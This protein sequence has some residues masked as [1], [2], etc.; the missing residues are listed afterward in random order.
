LALRVL[1]V[2]LGFYQRWEHVGAGNGVVLGAV[3]AVLQ[4]A[5]LGAQPRLQG[6]ARGGAA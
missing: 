1:Q 4:Q 5:L 3:G 6:V 2:A